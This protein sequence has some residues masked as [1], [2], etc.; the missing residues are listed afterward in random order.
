MTATTQYEKIG[1]RLRALRTAFGGLSQRAFAERHGFNPTQYNN[2]E[3]GVRRISFDCAEV[4]VD[5]Y[6]LSLDWLY[7]G[8]VDGLS[9]NARKALSSHL[10]I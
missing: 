2:W 8:R 9:E 5:T 10:A 6:G 4:L 7:R 1:L 3:L